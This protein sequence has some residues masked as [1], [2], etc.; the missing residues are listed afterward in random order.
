MRLT[1]KASKCTQT[2]GNNEWPVVLEKSCPP[3]ETSFIPQSVC[4]SVGPWLRQLLIQF[5]MTVYFSS[6]PKRESEWEWQSAVCFPCPLDWSWKAHHRLE[7]HQHQCQ[8]LSRMSYFGISRPSRHF[9]LRGKV[10]TAAKYQRASLCQSNSEEGRRHIFSCH[11]FCFLSNKTSHV[12]L[13]V[14][15]VAVAGPKPSSP[16]AICGQFATV[17]LL[18]G[19]LVD[20]FPLKK[21]TCRSVIRNGQERKINFVTDLPKEMSPLHICTPCQPEISLGRPDKFVLGRWRETA[22]REGRKLWWDDS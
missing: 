11:P 22:S 18:L 17:F 8:I 14:T 7:L 3:A 10:Y 5:T 20:I 19:I 15:H 13:S 4:Q 6:V 9:N 2:R 21:Q 1:P 12:L 16:S